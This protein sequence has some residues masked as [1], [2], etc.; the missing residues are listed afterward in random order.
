MSKKTSIQVEKNWGYEF[1]DLAI[2]EAMK[3]FKN[4]NKMKM[5]TD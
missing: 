1:E 3:K 2:T 5:Y 4:V